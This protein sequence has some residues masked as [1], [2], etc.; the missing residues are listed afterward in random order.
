MSSSVAV[1]AALLL[2]WVVLFVGIVPDAGR[3]RQVELTPH[4]RCSSQSS[5]A[6]AHTRVV[7][8][9]G[10][11]PLAHLREEW[12]AWEALKTVMLRPDRGGKAPRQGQGQNTGGLCCPVVMS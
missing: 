3:P 11:A 2:S 4:R 9:M 1:I 10:Y 12:K 8:L 6:T 5:A 7:V